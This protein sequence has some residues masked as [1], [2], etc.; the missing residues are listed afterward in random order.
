MIETYESL[1]GDCTTLNR[2]N[3]VHIALEGSLTPLEL[4]LM[5]ETVCNDAFWVNGERLNK[6]VPIPALRAASEQWLNKLKGYHDA[7]GKAVPEPF[8]RKEMLKT[9]TLFTDG[10]PRDGKTLLICFCGSGHRP[11]M[12][13]TSFI[14]SL[15]AVRVDFAVLRDIPYRSYRH[16]LAGVADSLETLQE[17][18]PKLLEFGRY[19]RICVLGISGGA[20]AALLT[21]LLGGYHAAIAVGAGRPDSI[22]WA[23]PD[24]STAGSRLAD[25]AKGSAT[26]RIALLYGAQSPR[27][28]T[29]AEA[30]ASIISATVFRIT[31]PVYV[32]AHNALYPLLGQGR[33]AAFLEEHLELYSA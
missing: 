14:Q 19:R 12:P 7:S 22:R 25:A 26:K 13:S 24:G 8:L 21:T 10:G 27:D 33:L 29:A 6:T 15:D 11:M 30:L 3:A 4:Q 23:D 5:W 17:E 32:V 1:L 28:Q 2:V 20:A 18:L 9:V 16:G 31:D